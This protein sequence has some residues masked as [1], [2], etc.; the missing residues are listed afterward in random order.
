[1][2]DR[3]SLPHNI[4]ANRIHWPVQNE[5]YMQNKEQYKFGKLFSKKQKIVILIHNLHCERNVV[6]N[7][8]D[9]TEE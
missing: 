3:L 8:F 5:K 2:L 6:M 9:H 1:M 7:Y 4:D